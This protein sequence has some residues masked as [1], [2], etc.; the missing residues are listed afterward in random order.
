MSRLFVRRSV[1]A[2]GIYSS[3][4]LG[5]AATVVAARLFDSTRTFGDYATVLFATALCQSFF[6]LTVEEALVKYGFRYVTSEDWG[7]FRWLFHIA[8]QFK[9]V[10][11]VS[12]RPDSS[13][14]HSSHRR[15]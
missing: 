7:R 2:V 12:R 15:G 3:V 13:S 10:G 6:D 5:V 8:L 1:T 14:S 11:S 4:V 9:L